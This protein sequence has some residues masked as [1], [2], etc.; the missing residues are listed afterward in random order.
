[1]KI[2][3]I[4]SHKLHMNWLCFYTKNFYMCLDVDFGLPE[5]DDDVRMELRLSFNM[6]WT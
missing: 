1:M 6:I 4:F 3:F 5:C 2:K